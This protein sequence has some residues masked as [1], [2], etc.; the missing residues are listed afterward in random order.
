MKIEK[1][2]IK[3]LFGKK[4]ICWELNPQVNVLVGVNGSG[5]S[6]ILSIINCF[7]N[8]NIPDSVED[9]ISYAKIKIDSNYIEL[10]IKNRV[11]EKLYQSVGEEKFNQFKKNNP[12]IY[13]E[14]ER[15]NK[16]FSSFLF[17][18]NG[19]FVKKAFNNDMNLNVEFI[20]ADVSNIYANQEL[21]LRTRISSNRLDF[22]IQDT[23]AQLNEMNNPELINKILGSLNIFFNQIDKYIS[24][25]N[26]E[27]IYKD[28][29][30]NKSLN[31]SSLSSGERQL[32]YIL[33]RVALSNGDKSKTS[34]ILMDEPEISLHLDWQEHFIKQ[35]TILNPDAQFII[36]THS[37]ALIM[38]GWNDVYVDMEEITTWQ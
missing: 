33:L 14:L 28:I 9:L 13:E 10:T 21:H 35:L 8:Q 29:I 7:L 20:S 30:L 34:I 22:E 11:L 19:D 32:I 23:I 16:L 5:K 2:E 24:Y 1:I 25:E 36:V 37:P 12:D 15:E 18:G 27:L 31:Y 26:N 3:G 38:N 4:D 17:G 6:T